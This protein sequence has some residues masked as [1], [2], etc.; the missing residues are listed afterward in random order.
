MRRYY[1]KHQ[2]NR[3]A[4]IEAWFNVV[5]WAEVLDAYILAT[6]E[7]KGTGGKEEV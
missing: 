7:S 4:Y 6:G 2:S 3:K 1:L 5:N